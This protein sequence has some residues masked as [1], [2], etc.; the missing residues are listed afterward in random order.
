MAKKKLEEKTV[1]AGFDP[2]SIGDEVLKL[3][4]SSFD[5]TFENVM[6]IQDLN[7]KMLKDM[8]EKGKEMR[9]D[10]VKMMNDLIENANRGRDKYRKVMEDGFK[11]MGEILKKQK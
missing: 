2:K 6:K 10:S 1:F 7:E 4:K 8:L 3:M 9:A 5:A 11:N